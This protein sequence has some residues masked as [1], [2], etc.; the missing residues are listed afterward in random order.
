MRRCSHFIVYLLDCLGA[1]FLLL[2]KRLIKKCL[3][4]FDGSL[5]DGH[6]WLYPTCQGGMNCP[7]HQRSP[8]ILLVEIVERHKQGAQVKKGPN[9]VSVVR[10]NNT[11]PCFQS[12]SFYG[13]AHSS[14]S[15][16]SW[17]L[18]DMVYRSHMIC[19]QLDTLIRCLCDWLKL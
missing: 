19:L 4:Q 17:S 1:S 15:F 14:K 9:H 10:K 16:H 6:P 2:F 7:S 18:C 11:P 12:I 3:W 5:S 8:L 13:I